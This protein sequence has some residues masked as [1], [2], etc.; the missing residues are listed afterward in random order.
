M[1]NLPANQPRL[2]CVDDNPSVLR[3]Y[4]LILAGFGY[5]VTVASSAPAAI[6][7]VNGHR[8]DLIIMDH[9]M[10]GTANGELA[11]RFR[12]LA[13]EVRL[14][15][16]SACSSVVEDG[17]HFVDASL[18]KNS[19]IEVLIDQ[20]EILL[21]TGTSSARPTALREH[22]SEVRPGCFQSLT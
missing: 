9:K 7:Q 22:V 19:P 2:L 1:R 11:T 3:M 14:I 8:P 5:A 13:S 10:F 6:R 12:Q 20:I 4:Q 21:R 17:A 15:L 16:V 18:S